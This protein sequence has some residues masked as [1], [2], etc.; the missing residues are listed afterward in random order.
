MRSKI[1]F[2]DAKL[3]SASRFLFAFDAK[4][5]AFVFAFFLRLASFRPNIFFLQFN[6]V[7][8]ERSKASLQFN[9]VKIERSE[10]SLQFNLV[11]RERT[12]AFSNFSNFGTRSQH[13]CIR[14][15]KK[16]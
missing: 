1:W 10:A 14:P 15:A 8:R 16:A 13:A 11:K 2:F 7:K 3:C 4:K 9:L 6:L 5:D 12:K